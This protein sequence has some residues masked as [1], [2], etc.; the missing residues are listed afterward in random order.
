[1]TAGPE[2]VSVGIV[3]A[4][5]IGFDH[6]RRLTSVVPG[7]RVAAVAD[8]DPLRAAALAK[9][10]PG[11]RAADS[12]HDVIT[13]GDVDAVLVTSTGPTHEEF[14]LAAIAAGK[15]VFCEK[16]LAPAPDACL[17]IVEAEMSRGRRLVQVGFMRRYDAGYRELKQILD[18]GLIGPPLLAHCAHRNVSSAGP[19]TDAMPLTETAVHEMDAIRWLLAE[20][21][22][23][24]TVVRPRRSSQAPGS[25]QDPQLLLMQTASGVHVDVEIFVNCRYGYDIRC[26]IVGET[27]T[28]ALPSPAQVTI[29]TAGQQ[30]QAVPADW[31][32]RFAA[33]YDTELAEWVTSVAEGTASGPTSW[34]GYAAAA[35][36]DAALTALDTGQR[37]PVV[38]KDRPPFYA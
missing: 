23:A 9:S 17:R 32:V 35:V 10:L 19:I 30:A 16:P 25:L 20:E 37:V 18:S 2:V 33:A 34:D 7:A 15:P 12:G 36:A 6:A 31:P 38:M 4:G 29:R 26:E 28:A 11:A 3:G 8:A 22:S 21:I 24:V 13:A 27:G 1:V 5:K 14:V